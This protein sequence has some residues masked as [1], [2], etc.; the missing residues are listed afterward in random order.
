MCLILL[1]FLY[2]FDFI[3]FFV[4]TAVPVFGHQPRLLISPRNGGGRPALSPGKPPK[5]GI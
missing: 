4:M 1:I 3:D 5:S 2:L